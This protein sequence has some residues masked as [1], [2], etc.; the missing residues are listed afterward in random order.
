[1]SAPSSA[2]RSRWPSAG[3]SRGGSPA[4]PVRALTRQ[5]DRLRSEL[6]RGL[7]AIADDL[8][9]GSGETAARLDDVR[10]HSLEAIREVFQLDAAHRALR[11]SPLR[12][13]DANAVSELA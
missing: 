11:W 5:F 1:M 4:P 8:A 10:A 12:R 6:I 7:A 3:R 13:R 9:T 2:L